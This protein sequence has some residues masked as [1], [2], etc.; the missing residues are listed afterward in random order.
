MLNTIPFD[1]LKVSI[2]LENAGMH[3][4][5]AESITKVLSEIFSKFI[6]NHMKE[7]ELHKKNIQTLISYI[8]S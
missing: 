7:N 1:T 2:Q 4:E 3:R 8:S 5:Q 6:E